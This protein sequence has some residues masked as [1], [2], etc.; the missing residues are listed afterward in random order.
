MAFYWQTSSDAIPREHARIGYEDVVRTATVTATSYAPDFAPSNVTSAATYDRWR[1]TA[2]PADLGVEFDVPVIIDYVAIGA[3]N[4]GTAGATVEVYDS[5]V[6]LLASVTPEDNSPIVVHFDALTSTN[7]TI[8]ILGSPVEIGVVYAGRLLAMMRPI[9]G[10]HTPGILSAD[11]GYQNNMSEAGQFLG[12]SIV[13][14]GYQES[15]TWNNLDPAWYRDKFQPFVAAAR[16]RPFFIAWRPGTFQDEVLFG[17]TSDDIA[18]VNT[19]VRGLMSV[20]LSI[21]AVS[22]E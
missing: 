3:H 22:G 17:W 16:A 6:G 15:F 11:T 13:R 7:I 14:L 1:P 4:A 12:R 9:Y 18:P 2:V 8:R 19:G 10:G 5:A 21:N 20:N